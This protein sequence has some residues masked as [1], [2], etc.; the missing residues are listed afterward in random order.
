MWPSAQRRNPG[1]SGRLSRA[2]RALRRP[3]DGAMVSP[4]SAPGCIIRH[5]SQRRQHTPLVAG[6]VIPGCEILCGGQCGNRPRAGVLR[7]RSKMQHRI[8]I[9]DDSKLARMVMVSAFRRIRPECELIEA[10][11]AA[12][13]LKAISGN[14]VDIALVD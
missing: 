9:V 7:G 6:S 8:L 4:C 1:H 12:E 5:T 13:A 10:T 11:D 3:L 14:A 2:G